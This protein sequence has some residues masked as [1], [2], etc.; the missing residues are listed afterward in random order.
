MEQKNLAVGTFYH[1]DEIMG[2]DHDN[3]SVS[4]RHAEKSYKGKGATPETLKRHGLFRTLFP[5]LPEN[6]TR[7]LYNLIPGTERTPF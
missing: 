6:H 7:S 1:V 4:L 3:N 5:F 2:G